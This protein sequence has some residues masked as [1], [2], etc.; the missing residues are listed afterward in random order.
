[1][2][3]PTLRLRFCM[4][5]L[6]ALG[7]LAGLGHAT[8]VTLSPTGPAVVWDRDVTI[9]GSVSSPGPVT[10][11]LFVQGKAIPFTLTATSFT[12][13]VQLNQ[14]TN[15]IV[16]RI[17]CAGVLTY[18]DTLLLTLGYK[19]QPECFAYPVVSGNNVTLH[20]SILDNPDSSALTFAWTA[21]ASNPSGIALT[22]PNDSVASFTLPFS[23]PSGEYYFDVT[24]RSSGD[25]VKA[26]TLVT[27]DSSGVRAFNTQTDHVRWIDSA[28]IYCASPYMF[29]T[30]TRLSHITAKLPEI[31]QLGAT[32][33][34][35]QPIYTTSDPDQGY[36]VLDYFRI[37]TSLG[38]DA[39]L[40]TL[41]ATAHQLGLRVL[42]DF[43]PN[44]SG[45]QHPYAQDAIAKGPRSHYYDFYQRDVISGQYSYAMYKVHA[46]QMDFIQYFSGA[47]DQVY[48]FPAWNVGNPEVQ[49][50]LTEAGKY[51][52]EKFDVDGYRLDALWG[53][54]DR[55]PQF[56]KDFRVALKRV[57]PEILLIGE[58][59]ASWPSA[60]DGRMDAAYDWASEAGWVSHWP[61]QVAYTD[62]SQASKTIFNTT[63]EAQRGAQLASALTNKGA[64]FPPGAR[65]FRFMENNDLPHFLANH[66]LETTKM[67][68]ALLFTL[69]GIPLLFNGQEVGIT[70]HPYIATPIYS[71]SATMR[72]KDRLGL[73]GYYSSLTAMRKRYPALMEGRFDLTPI[74]SAP[75]S[76]LAFQ[77]SIEMQNIFT[78]LNMG[79]SAAQARLQLPI[80]GLRLDSARTY[81][82]TDYLTGETFS[83]TPE[84][85]D[86]VSV[87]LSANTARVLI[88]DTVAIKV[89]GIAPTADAAVPAEL[90]LAQNYPNPFNPTTGVRF[91]V[92]G[93]SDVKLVVYDILGREIAV[94]V[95]ERKTPGSYEVTFDGRGLAS[96]VY[97]YRLT[98]G[99]F[100]QTRKMLLLK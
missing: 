35:I 30:D 46:G 2:R 50:M 76:L 82:L 24:V 11:T 5:L 90:S 15:A 88:L 32:A 91:Q 77:R 100:V 44:H 51:W 36:H 16:A 96:G 33:V 87:P 80:A 64:G 92:A 78:V 7:V 21:R 75:G 97:I 58:D 45:V 59:K 29:T 6:P 28:I 20:A 17:D 25:T 41:V 94:L 34:W 49:R 68:A 63:A 99:T 26:S 43:V 74:V 37:R 40:R 72:S 22:N 23:A 62:W 86:S 81:F 73:F 54:N 8:T 38:S 14:G 84:M 12:V 27:L 52:I 10:G 53:V 31:A 56:M 48:F 55:N 89:T 60:F 3:L 9:T 79:S 57:K 66:S 65:V 4:L 71:S 95:N 19:I 83:G 85:L 47:Y 98:A 13:P 61:W 18:S 42:L 1:M 39:D 67:A 70:S 69:D 93:V